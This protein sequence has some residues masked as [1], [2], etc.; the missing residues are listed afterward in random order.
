MPAERNGK[1]R[2]RF[3]GYFKYLPANSIPPYADFSG[4]E[5][6]GRSQR[7]KMDALFP[8]QGGPCDGAGPFE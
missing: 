2:L 1:M 6:G 4:S 5:T 8:E 3:I 7:G